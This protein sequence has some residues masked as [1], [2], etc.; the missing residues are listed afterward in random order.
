MVRPVAGNEAADAGVV[1]G[2]GL[3]GRDEEPGALLRT[4][5]RNQQR[6]EVVGTELQRR[7]AGSAVAGRL[8]ARDAV[9]D[10]LDPVGGEAVR[11]Q[12][13]NLRVGDR[14]DAVDPPRHEAGQGAPVP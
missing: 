9:R 1:A 10:H 11:D 7:P 8:G 6:D 13:R 4:E 12:I 2:G 3:H 5:G 14:D